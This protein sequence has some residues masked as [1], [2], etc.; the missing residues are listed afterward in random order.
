MVKT[1][2][3]KQRI[4]LTILA[5]AVLAVIGLLVVTTLQVANKVKSGETYTTTIA[6]GS[7][8]RGPQGDKGDQGPPPT[9]TQISQAVYDYCA[10]TGICNGT[11]PSIEVVFAAVSK[12]CESGNCKGSNG[13]DATPISADQI[14]VAVNSYC[15]NGK[16]RGADG[17]T[18]ATGPIGATG[19]SGRTTELACVQRAVNGGQ[20]KYV[21]WKYTDEAAAA[22][23]DLYKLPVWAEG[24]NCVQV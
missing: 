12:Y 18:G 10:D 15:S 14:Q 21:A 19:A 3:R 13:K 17:A 7:P 1:M 2:T 20:A 5:G 16:C 24:V 6:P 4:L 23:R 22:Y 8:T 11:N 9:P